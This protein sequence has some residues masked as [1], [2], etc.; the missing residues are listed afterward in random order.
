MRD[1]GSLGTNDG[2]YVSKNRLFRNAKL[3][4][5]TSN[6]IQTLER[7][8]IKRIVD[9]RGPKEAL[10]HP[11]RM[12]GGTAIISSPIIGSNAGDEIDDTAIRELVLGASLPETVLEVDRVGHHGHYYRMLFLVNNYGTESHTSRLTKYRAL[13]DLGPDE[14]MLVHCIGGRDRTGGGIALLLEAP[15]V[16]QQDIEADFVASNQALQSDRED[17][18]L[19]TFLRFTSAN[20]FLQPPANKNNQRVA[21]ELGAFPESIRDAVILRPNLKVEVL[22]R[23][24]RSLLRGNSGFTQTPKASLQDGGGVTQSSGS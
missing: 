9:L 13:L 23:P 5:I 22:L 4:H 1:L 7:L 3:A 11:D 6:D 10:D 15:G 20:V 2:R 14:A 18:D 12:P 8:G 21:E 16:S 17:P 19:T 24:P